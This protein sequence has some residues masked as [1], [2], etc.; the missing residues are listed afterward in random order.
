[1]PDANVQREGTMTSTS[2][3][4]K[5]IEKSL[6]AQIEEKRNLY[7]KK[8][9]TM[10]LKGEER[11]QELRSILSRLEDAIAEE[12]R[13]RI[14]GEAERRA[15]EKRVSEVRLKVREMEEENHFGSEMNECL[16]KNIT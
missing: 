15:V 16:R 4:L 11:E 9:L 8:L 7:E 12:E 6:T 10:N 5:K 13:I 1:M 3:V 14:E 2:V